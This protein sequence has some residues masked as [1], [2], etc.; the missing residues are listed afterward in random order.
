MGEEKA[1]E[2]GIGGGGGGANLYG[3]IAGSVFDTIEVAERVEKHQ[4][5][6]RRRRNFRRNAYLTGQ[7]NK[8]LV[9]RFGKLERG[10]L[11]EALAAQ[12]AGY[13]TASVQANKF[14][15]NAQRRAI[16]TEE[17]SFGDLS[18]ALQGA[19]FAG[20]SSLAG[21]ARRGVRADTQRQLSEIDEALSQV[22]ADLAIG[23]GQAEAQGKTQIAGSL[24][25]QGQ[26]LININR[27]IAAAY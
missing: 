5:S 9:E 26:Q 22:F 12:L 20:N 24:A 14:G 4:A 8:A 16:E 15:R 21:N 23:R 6:K 11:E 3:D 2:S 10:K 18:Q 13:D 1:T 27:A 7:A 25:R 17:Q 19:G